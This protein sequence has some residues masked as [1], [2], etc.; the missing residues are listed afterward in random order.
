[1]HILTRV[2]FVVFFG[3]YYFKVFVVLMAPK[4]AAAEMNP[5]AEKEL[6]EEQK[7]GVFVLLCL[8]LWCFSLIT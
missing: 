5:G 1:M 4:K 8:I 2:C 7:T 3:F 6:N